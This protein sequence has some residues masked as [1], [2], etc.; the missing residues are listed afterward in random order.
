MTEDPSL[1]SD[2]F[3]NVAEEFAYQRMLVKDWR[4]VLM[5]YRDSVLR[6]GSVRQLVAK[7]IGAGVVEIRLKPL[8]KE[9]SNP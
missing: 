9:E 7:N 8:P 3:W 4:K 6:Q 5:E 1:I 2:V